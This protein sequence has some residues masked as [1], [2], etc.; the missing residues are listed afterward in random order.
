MEYRKTAGTTIYDALADK[1]IKRIV[2]AVATPKRMHSPKAITAW[3]S[4]LIE[5][6]AINAVE[7]L[8]AS[9][10][11]LATIRPISSRKKASIPLSVV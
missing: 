10:K 9:F 1:T 3:S 6:Y 5:A 11:F 8:A 2:S 4:G 7:F